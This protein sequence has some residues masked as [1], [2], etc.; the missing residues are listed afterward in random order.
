GGQGFVYVVWRD[1]GPA[2]EAGIRFSLS[3]NGG[4]SYGPSGGTSIAP[5]GAL[6]VQGAFVTVGPDHAVYV[7]WLDQSAGFSTPNIIKMRKSTNFGATFGPV[8]PIKTLHTTG[9]NGDLALNGG[10][11]SNAFAQA[12]VNP[13]TA[14]QLYLVYND[15]TSTPCSTSTDHGDV[16]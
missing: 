6:N 16:F 7:F 13:T 1:F 5:P 11:R 15:C 3:T 9:I 10:F 8:V 4:A 2:S 12:V 14:S